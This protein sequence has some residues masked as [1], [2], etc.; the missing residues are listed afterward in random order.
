MHHCFV[1][2]R[3]DWNS[4]WGPRHWLSGYDDRETLGAL[5]CREALALVDDISA[6]G[7]VI[8][9]D[10]LQVINTLH[11]SLSSNGPDKPMLQ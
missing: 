9:S 5:A 6:C 4:S 10:C 8:A 11:N 3:D 7:A 2:A 1:V